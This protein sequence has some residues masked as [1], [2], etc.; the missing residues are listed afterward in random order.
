M[1]T[2]SDYIKFTQCYKYLW[3][4]KHRKD[5]LPEFEAGSK[6][7]FD[8]GYTVEKY[9]YK[10]FPDGE[11]AYAEQISDAITNTQLMINNGRK[12]IF[13]ATVSDYKLF[14]RADII[15]Y[16]T[17]TELWDIYE[18]KSTTEVK[19]VHLFDLAF[20]KIC[21]E[22]CKVRIGKVYLVHLNNKYVRHGDIEPEKLF[23][24]TDVTDDVMDL[25]KEVKLDI[26]RAHEIL[27]MTEEP[28]VKILNQCSTPYE[29]AFMEYCWQHVP[30]NSIYDIAGGLPDDKLEM[31]VDQGILEIKDIPK[32]C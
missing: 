2:K 10:L 22:Q 28:K 11:D 8:E 30:E 24:K 23:K 31:L 19:A 6:Q 18:V 21:F 25:I 15:K 7:V 13:Q 17:R 26:K 29:C 9:A 4:H 20:Q 3:L 1:L 27:N 14:C 12:T 32:A 5:L 16:N